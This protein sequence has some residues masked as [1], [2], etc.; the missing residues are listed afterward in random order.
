MERGVMAGSLPLAPLARL[1]PSRFHSL[2]EC[3]LREV[4]AAAGQAWLLPAAPAARLGSAIHRLFEGAGKGHF[5]DGG[6]PAVESRWNELVGEAEIAMRGS[7]LESH[8]VPLKAAVA[9]YEV[10]RL[11]SIQ[12]AEEI[13]RS[14]SPA[15][16]ARGGQP[17]CRSE[18]WVSTPDGRVGG[19]IDQ[20][21]DSPA[22][23]ILRDYKSG[24]V[25]APGKAAGGEQIKESYEVQL[26]L[27]AA[28]YAASAGVWPTR[29]ELVPLQGPV[30]EVAFTAAECEAVLGQ[31]REALMTVN[32]IIAN[33]SAPDAEA[34]MAAPSQEACRYCPFRPGCASYHR[35]RDSR[36]AED[37]WPQDVWGTVRELEVLGNGKVLLGVQP[38][39]GGM[40]TAVIRGI[41]PSADRH[42]GLTRLAAGDGVAVYDLKAA[43]PGGTF[44][45]SSRTT[46]YRLERQG[47]GNAA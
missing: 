10:R 28:I 34:L 15:T 47:A 18:V 8:L 45:E 44:Q 2:M 41:N 17:R 33:N 39:D 30:R 4:W 12:R 23:P 24:H 19:F 21:E 25:L 27:Y 36:P 43:G 7:W 46:I 32:S 22:G 37:G 3:A 38:A 42:P 35:A 11:R 29:L 6:R 31:A 5:R 1:S 9:D 20:V 16:G 26:K 40:G 13:T 14:I